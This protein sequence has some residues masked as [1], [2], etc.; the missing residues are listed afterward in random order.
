AENGCFIKTIKSPPPTRG[1][2]SLSRSFS[3]GSSTSPPRSTPKPKSPTERSRDGEWVNMVA[4]FNLS[5]KTACL[6]ILS[7]MLM[8]VHGQFTER[9]PGAFIEERDASIVYRFWTGGTQPDGSESTDR[10]WARRQAA[11]AQ[12]HI[13]DRFAVPSPPGPSSFTNPQS[14]S[15]GERYGLRIIPGRNSFLV[16]PNN[17]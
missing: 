3:S 15:L 2:G 7:Y 16:L 14:Q 5:W 4:N 10:Q 6:E 17:V 13:F 1:P 9:T 11:E 8:L 12:N